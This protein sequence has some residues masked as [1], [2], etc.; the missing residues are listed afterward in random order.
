MASC[1]RVALQAQPLKKDFKAFE[2]RQDYEGKMN[3][4]VSRDQIQ[5]LG[6]GWMIWARVQ[7]SA[8]ETMVHQGPHDE[9]AVQ[10]RLQQQTGI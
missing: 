7:A 1:F 5:H 10:N 2:S 6:E 9:A 8:W 3:A 4:M